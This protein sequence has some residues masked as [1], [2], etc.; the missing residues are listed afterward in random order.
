LNGNGGGI[1][2]AQWIQ[3]SITSTGALG[4]L[5]LSA[6]QGI[7]ADVVAPTIIGNIDAV[8]GPISGTI[9]TTL[10]DLGRVFTDASGNIT[11]VTYIHAAAGGIT[12][13]IISR[14][15]LISSIRS[16]GGM[17]GLI[18]AQGNIGTI[19]RNPATGKAVVGTDVAHSLTRFGGILVNGGMSGQIVALGNVF[20]DIT[21]NGGI[22]G[23]IAVHGQQLSELAA[24]RYGILGRLTING[25]IDANAA[26]VS[27]GVIG[28]DGVYVVGTTDSDAYGTQITFG[29]DKGI[30]AAD[31]DINFGQTG[32]IYSA[33][34]F[35]NAAGTT[36]GAVIN[37]IFTQ[38][39]VPLAFDNGGLDLI[40][41]D[42]AKLRVDAKTG[43]LTGTV[44]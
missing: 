6:S 35:E 15:N 34:V 36:N 13:K 29:S 3:T 20:G 10:G 42:L 4:D 1:Q 8:N 28:D 12:G 17:S 26:I 41:G 27:G 40:L 33:G 44:A 9:K 16:D 32:K 43:N 25:T 14:V 38:G 5:I 30:L 18:A 24:G 22:S 21:L 23:R 7:T 11:G 19:Q 39:N 2:T 31:F 37:A